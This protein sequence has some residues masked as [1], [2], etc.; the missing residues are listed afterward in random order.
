M[1]YRLKIITGSLGLAL[2][3]CTVPVNAQL[4]QDTA[5]LRLVK[6]DID[7]IY[8]LQFDSAREVYTK[9][10]SL[11][12]GHPIVYLLRG[13][14]TYWEN[15]PMLHTS[16]SHNLFEEDLHQCI[17]LSEENTN[18][19]YEAEYL[20]S[21]L[22]ARGM[23]LTFYD[24]ND[25]IMDVIPLMTGTYKHLRRAFDFVT[26]SA[27]FY[28]FSGI[29]KYYREAFPRIYPVYKS[30]A[31]LFPH[32]DM[33]TGLKELQK[34]ALNSVVLK[35]ESCSLLTLIY[36]NYENKLP[37]STYYSKTLHEMYP[38][39][40]GFLCTYIR[41]LLLLKK[42]D[43]AEKLLM[44]SSED[45]GNKFFQAQFVILRGILQEKEH[46]NY[47]LAQLY[48]NNGISDISLFGKYGNEYAAYAYFGLSRVSDENGGK[49]THKIYRR[50]AMKLADFKKINFDK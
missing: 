9:I 32:G 19:D 29:Y 13:L 37:E 1:N 47:K 21:D 43:E 38:G 7:Y 36:L 25:L 26:V 30:L 42:Y 44:A 45:E 12:T 20:L 23:L 10:I 31:L 18:P 35:A 22:C 6:E 4:L 41:N 48:Y 11:Y 46:H 28:Y 3:L 8:N 15:Y 33:E 2:F 24:D 16:P 40:D 27:D 17:R 49:Q 34:A 50:E 39:N 5:A 14:T